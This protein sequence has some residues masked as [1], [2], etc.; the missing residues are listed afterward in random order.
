M[1]FESLGKL[2]VS[3]AEMLTPAEELTVAEASAKYV[4]LNN[5]G[6]YVGPWQNSSV[7]YMV[8]PMNTFTSPDFSGLI[9]VAPAQSAKTQALILNTLA[10]SIKVEPMDMMLVCP[11]GADGRDF[12]IRRVDRLHFHSPKIG[13]MLVE[14][15]QADNVYD[16]HYRN[17]MLFTIVSPTRTALAGKPVPRVVMTDRDRMPDDVDGDGEP[18]DLASKRTTTFGRYAMTVAESSPSRPV[19]N[20]KWIPATPHEAPPCKGILELYNRG[21]RRRWYWPCPHCG[22]YFE[23]KFKHLQWVTEE[24]DNTLSNQDRGETVW[25]TC[26]INGCVIRPDDRE[27]MQFWGKWVR[28]GQMV[29]DDGKIIGPA[30]RTTIASFWLNG[31]AATFT[32][33]KKL[34]TAY[35]DAM[36]GFT[37]TKSEDALKKF[38]NNDLGEPYVPRSMTEIRQPETLKARA[39]R[40]LPERRVPTGVRFLVAT[41]DTQKNMWRVNVYGILPGAPFDM[42]VV[43][44]YDVRK[45]QRTDHDGERLWVKPQTYLEDWDELTE[46]V[47]DREYELDD[48]S[49]R[50]MGIKHIGCDMHGIKG[51][52]TMAYNYWRKLRDDNKHRRFIL[53]RGDSAPG[54]PRARITYPDSSHKDQKAGA[55]GDIPVLQFNTNILKDDLDGRIDCMEPGKGMFRYG[56]WLPDV[57][58][59]E[60]CS[61]TRTPT[62]W[63]NPS[64]AR[65]EDWDLSGYAIGL[66]VSELIRVEGIRWENPPGWAAEWDRNDLVRSVDAAK[67]FATGVNSPHDFAALA[68]SLA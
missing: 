29:G 2:F 60:M 30:P 57:F 36:D 49:G 55:R 20:P 38:Y 66:C 68:K 63:V 45:S 44:R 39:E 32:N 35:L 21:D 5:P 17:G 37:R 33:W 58:Y 28:D 8:E 6:A 24:S 18:Y 59:G 4:E 61:E 25:M 31:V 54:A 40:G 3:L 56:A 23:G 26:P 52:T 65:N 34:V 1:V 13:E 48:G 10:Y 51:V 43:D 15:A 53:L 27:D 14:G 7:W 46:H 19:D 22:S 9:F 50:L 16:K 12:S 42:V 64:G 67:P 47:I 41:V 62:G 11:T